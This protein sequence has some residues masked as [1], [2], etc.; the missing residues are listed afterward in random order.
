MSHCCSPG[1]LA[2]SSGVAATV[3]PFEHSI[4]VRDV[5]PALA[6][7]PEQLGRLDGFEHAGVV[8][9]MCAAQPFGLA[10]GARLLFGVETNRLQQLVACRVAR[11]SGNEQ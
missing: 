11:R 2:E 5:R 6:G 10:R 1:E 9:G 8:I 3:D 7:G 4:V